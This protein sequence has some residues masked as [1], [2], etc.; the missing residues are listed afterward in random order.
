MKGESRAD[1]YLPGFGGSGR[2]DRRGSSRGEQWEKGEDKGFPLVL[3]SSFPFLTR[4]RALGGAEG[5]S[6]RA[7]VSVEEWRT[8]ATR[9]LAA[10]GKGEGKRSETTEAKVTSDV[11]SHSLLHSLCCALVPSWV[12]DISYG[13]MGTFCRRRL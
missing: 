6:R 7:K 11:H 4:S 12:K 3:L 13:D 5:E 1:C 10:E 2:G 8:R 9:R